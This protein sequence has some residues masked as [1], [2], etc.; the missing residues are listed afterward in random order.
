M[1]GLNKFMI[2]LTNMETLFR[3]NISSKE[4]LDEAREEMFNSI[5]KPLVENNA[6]DSAVYTQT[7]GQALVELGKTYINGLMSYETNYIV[8]KA[9]EELYHKQAEEV[10]SRIALNEAQARE[11][12]SKIALNTE[13][14]E[15]YAAQKL[16]YEAQARETLEKIGGYGISTNYKYLTY[17]GN[18]GSATENDYNNGYKIEVVNGLSIKRPVWAENY[19]DDTK[20]GASIYD[21]QKQLLTAQT[22]EAEAGTKEKSRMAIAY[23]DKKEVKG[24]EYLAQMSTLA[25]NTGSNGAATAYS[26]ALVALHKMTGWNT[27]ATS[28]TAANFG[29]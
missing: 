13:Q 28:F 21:K 10:D 18:V 26:N 29:N 23:D 9:Q 16:A 1:K 15:L 6:V 2:D 8:A 20:L 19:I 11:V 24:M 27:G 7:L 17:D 12:D 14:V 5:L 22:Q 25:I 3:S 4:T